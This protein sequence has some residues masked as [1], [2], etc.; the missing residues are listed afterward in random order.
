MQLVCKATAARRRTSR[1]AGLVRLPDGWQVDTAIRRQASWL[2]GLAEGFPAPHSASFGHR[3]LGDMP[4]G[5]EATAVARRVPRLAGLA[6][7]HLHH[8]LHPLGVGLL[9][10]KSAGRGGTTALIEFP[11]ARC[12]LFVYAAFLFSDNYFRIQIW[13]AESLM[14]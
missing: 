11:A 12:P 5:R 7:G 4:A 6:V 2:A 10:E 14:L 9:G 13:P 1:L 8:A 3:A